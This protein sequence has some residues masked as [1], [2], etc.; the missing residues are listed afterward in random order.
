M[1]HHVER[2]QIYR[3]PRARPGRAAVDA[4]HRRGTGGAGRG[5]RKA[6]ASLLVAV[7]RLTEQDA[8]AQRTEGAKSWLL[9]GREGSHEAA[10]RDQL[11]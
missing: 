2:G 4:G 10:S 7:F 5:G 9:A 11:A 1:D 8:R 6:A 3:S